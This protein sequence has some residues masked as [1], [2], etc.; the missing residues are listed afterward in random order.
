GPVCPS[1]LADDRAGSRCRRFEQEHG[2]PPDAGPIGERGRGGL[3]LCRKRYANARHHRRGQ[4]KG[5][6]PP[7]HGGPP[8]APFPVIGRLA[9]DLRLTTVDLFLWLTSQKIP[10]RESR[11]AACLQWVDTVEKVSAK[12]TWN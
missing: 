8:F 4:K 2:T 9:S 11:S 5:A 1:Q 3:G 12:E 10:S 7:A 6:A